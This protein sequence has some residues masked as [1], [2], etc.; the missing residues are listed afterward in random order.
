MPKKPK[1]STKPCALQP[2]FANLPRKYP[3]TCEG[4]RG[5]V[6]PLSRAQSP[7]GKR[8]SERIP[9]LPISPF[10]EVPHL[11][12]GVGA[13]LCHSGPEAPT[14]KDTFKASLPDLESKGDHLNQ[15]PNPQMLT[16][17][18][19]VQS[20]VVP[21]NVHPALMAMGMD[22][23]ILSRPLQLA[24]RLQHFLS[25]WQLLTRDQF[26]L[27]MVLGIQIPFTIFPHQSRVPPTHTSQPVRKDCHRSGDFG[28]APERGNSGGLPYEWG[29]SQFSFPSQAERWGKQTCNQL[30]RVEF[31]CNIP[32][33][34]NGGSVFTETF[35]SDW[36]LDDKNRFERCL[37]YC[38]SKQTT[39]TPFAFHAQGPEIPIFLS[40]L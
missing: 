38:A 19:G 34:Q 11:A 6:L 32:A 16:K 20:Q 29:I 3:L 39:S 22:T 1:S 13:D 17:S 26:I 2:R 4:L 23:T 18:L 5:L 9:E 7:P 25:N 12:V 21:V 37:L 28:D 31:L 33:F 30:E 36:G 35:D 8:F 10:E 15:A 24:G 27:E 40:P 14:T